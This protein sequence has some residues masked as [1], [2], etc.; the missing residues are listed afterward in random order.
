MMYLPQKEDK[1]DRLVDLLVEKA[2]LNQAQARKA[3]QVMDEYLDQK[4]P[5]VSAA[6]VDVVMTGQPQELD[7]AREIGLFQ[8]P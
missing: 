3:I 1:M 8:I 2:G 4:L 6:Q 7:L 5:E